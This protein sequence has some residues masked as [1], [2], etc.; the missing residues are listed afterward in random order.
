M[1]LHDPP[2]NPAAYPVQPF[3]AR[4]EPTL[5]NPEAEAFY[6]EALR[7]LSDLGIPFLLAGTYAVAAYTGI[8][9]PTKDLDVFCKAGDYP[10]I[11]AHFQ[12]LGYV[13]EIEDERWL[14]KVYKGED[15]F[16]VIFASQ[17]GTM[18]VG[19]EWFEHARQIEV[20]GAPALII[21]PTEL[22]WSKC[23]IQF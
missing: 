2:A 14:G 9:R 23:F 3:D 17:N 21:G 11:L 12:T 16:D 19:D 18:P 5:K 15:F 1:S 10:R 7:E 20:F 8:A 13:V 6:T 4:A 22:I